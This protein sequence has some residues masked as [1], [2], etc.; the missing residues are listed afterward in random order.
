[1]NEQKYVP[2]VE[3]QGTFVQE[4]QKKNGSFKGFK[5]LFATVV[6]DWRSQAGN[7]MVRIKSVG[8]DVQQ[9]NLPAGVF[10]QYAEENPDS[11]L[12]FFNEDKTEWALNHECPFSWDPI[13]GLTEK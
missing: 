7:D 5:G 1:M 10:I 13:E 8:D 9:Y 4:W 11:K 3:G 6:T 2:V 12:V